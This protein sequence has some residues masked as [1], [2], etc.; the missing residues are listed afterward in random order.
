MTSGTSSLSFDRMAEAAAL[1]RESRSSTGVAAHAGK[2]SRAA[3][4][5]ALASSAEALG[6]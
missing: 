1:N 4:A 2:A 6:A 3:R 5:A